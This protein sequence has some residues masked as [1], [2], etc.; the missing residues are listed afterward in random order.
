MKLLSIRDKL[1]LYS[2]AI[3]FLVASSIT[4]VSYYNDRESTLA[5]YQNEAHKIVMLLQVSIEKDLAN[6]NIQG[7]KDT[8]S[9]LRVDSD[10]H[11]SYV[12]DKSGKVLAALRSV[13]E[14]SVQM[15]D[16]PHLTDILHSEKLVSYFDN[17]FL[18]VG[19]PVVYEGKTYAYLYVQ[20]ALNNVY[21]QLT[22]ALYINLLVLVICMGGGLIL[23]RILSVNFTQPIYDM[24]QL[25]NK[26]SEGDHA[27]VFPKRGTEELGVLGKSLEAMLQNLYQIHKKLEDAT[28]ELDHKVKE[29]TQE[30]EVATQKARDANEEKSRFLANVSHEIRTPMT[31][32]IGAANLIKN[33]PLNQEQRKYVGIM[34]LSAESLLSLINDILDLSKIESGK[35]EVENMNFNLRTIVDDVMD[36]LAYRAREKNLALGYVIDPK[37]PVEIIGDPTR[38]KQILINLVGNAI[39][40]TE[41]GAITI[42]ITEI[43]NLA[44]IRKIRFAVDDTG[45]GIPHEKQH[46]LFKAFTQAD[47]STTRQFG[48]TGLGLTISKKLAQIMGGDLNVD[49]TPGKGSTFY[50]VIDCPKTDTDLLP[51]YDAT[52]KGKNVF[53][54][55][56]QKTRIEFFDYFMKT[57]GITHT[58]TEKSDLAESALK[59]YELNKKKWELIIIHEPLL[60]DSLL[61]TI[62]QYHKKEDCAVI[63]LSDRSPLPDLQPPLNTMHA[64][65]IGPPIKESALYHAILRGFDLESSI[66]ADEPQVSQAIIPIDKANHI[67]I[68]VV[69]DNMISQQISIKLLE[70]LGF[71]VHGASSGK[72]AIEAM[73]LVPFDLVFMDCQMPEMDGFE[74]T[75]R[76]R[77]N[78]KFKA[79]PIVALTANAMKSDEEACL[80][81]GMTDFLTKPVK[82]PGLTKVIQRYLSKIIA[83]QENRGEDSPPPPQS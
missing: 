80:D 55:D 79:T 63:V 74:T 83:N 22:T 37:L 29:R 14:Q 32:I 12:I 15:L 49:S 45:I 1:V 81:A 70:K 64:E 30:L 58:F 25:T 66:D 51:A 9:H 82:A 38:I 52:L 48:G 17:T 4:A 26:I 68:L 50:M 60:T 42:R 3:I 72:E 44:K 34:E 6:N 62:M 56:D 46:K 24:I 78:D 77:K 18:V 39:K 47:T 73:D 36:L 40:F 13:N 10:I 5:A 27:I 21:Q 23:A 59:T 53:I 41:T 65:Y 57:L 28:V 8:V 31:G 71:Q 2:C 7:V 11:N 76:L 16:A 69:D 35:I 54:I 43:D 20:F 19:A 67:H 61:Q 75:R 33:T